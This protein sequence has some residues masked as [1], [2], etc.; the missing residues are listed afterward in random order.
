MKRQRGQS[1]PE[2]AVLVGVVTI[3]ATGVSV[4]IPQLLHSFDS[5]LVYIRGML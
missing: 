2:Y 4:L 1:V 5:A 3:L